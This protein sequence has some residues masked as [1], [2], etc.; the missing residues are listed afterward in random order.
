MM[1]DF[2]LYSPVVH[3]SLIH[4]TQDFFF[5]L[6]SFN[7]RMYSTQLCKNAVSEDTQVLYVL[8]YCIYFCLQNLTFNILQFIVMCINMHLLNL[9]EYLKHIFRFTIPQLLPKQTST[10][11]HVHSY[12]F[13]VT[14]FRCKYALQRSTCTIRA[15][16]YKW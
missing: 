5:T 9:I 16:S 10:F 4:S 14:L 1:P 8:M 11:I 13:Y 7:P 6:I 2:L 3:S 12:S 15:K